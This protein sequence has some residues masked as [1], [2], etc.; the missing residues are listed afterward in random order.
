MVD[1]RNFSIYSAQNLLYQIHVHYGILDEI[2]GL[3]Q[4]R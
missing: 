4:D 1:L 3:I 2:G